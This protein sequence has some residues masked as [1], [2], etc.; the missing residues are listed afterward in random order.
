MG[1]PWDQL[2]NHFD[3][4]FV[5]WTT[6]LQ[7]GFQS[8]FFSD[9]GMDMA[10]GCDAQMCLKH[11]KYC[12]FRSI[13]SFG[14]VR[15]LGVPG[16]DLGF[17]LGGFWRPWVHF[18]SFLGVPERCWNFDGFSMSAVGPGTPRHGGWGGIIGAPTSPL[19]L[20][21]SPKIE[22]EEKRRS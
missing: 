22:E 2:W 19:G 13:Y 11:N 9:L 18:S 3:D 7:C 1:A 12:C 16:K 20:G 15:V 8:G 17:I 21:L 6:Q 10:P 14:K 4:F 5:I